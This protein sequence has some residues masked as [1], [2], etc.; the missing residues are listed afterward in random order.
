MHIKVSPLQRTNEAFGAPVRFWT[1]YGRKAWHQAERVDSE[2]SSPC[3][4][5]TA[6]A[7][8]RP[9]GPMRDSGSKAAR[10]CDH[11]EVVDRFA[12]KANRCGILGDGLPIIGANQ[13][14]APNH[15]A[16]VARYIKSIGFPTCFRAI[17]NSF[18]LVRP[19]RAYTG[20]PRKQQLY[21]SP[22]S[23]IAFLVQQ[24]QPLSNTFFVDGGGDAAKTIGR[25]LSDGR[26]HDR[27][28]PGI[29]GHRVSATPYW[30]YFLL[31]TPSQL[32][33]RFAQSLR[34][35]LHGVT[36]SGSTVSRGIGFLCANSSAPRRIMFPMV[37]LPMMHRPSRRRLFN[38]LASA[39]ATTTPLD[40]ISC[41][42]PSVILGWHG[43]WS[44]RNFF[45]K[46]GYP[47]QRCTSVNPEIIPISYLSRDLT[48]SR[49][50][51][52]YDN[53]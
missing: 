8:Q 26:R 30:Q 38:S 21:S 11:R 41:L 19:L 40:W 53:H 25:E 4:I 10:E 14:G 16:T 9:K 3:R 43:F 7:G 15:S 44:P 22:D 36:P 27:H 13:E 48:L 35:G 49:M 47:S 24:W 42:S 28:H 46:R 37:F 33:V 17:R 12:V 1:S 52:Y 18:A 51:R 32:L 34:D 31:Y 29:A 20:A 39:V 23:L 2:G 6:I 5:G 50:A 45:E